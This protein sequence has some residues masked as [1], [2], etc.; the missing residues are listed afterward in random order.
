M[1]LVVILMSKVNGLQRISLAM[2]TA[3]LVHGVNGQAAPKLAL[4]TQIQPSLVFDPGPDL[5]RLL[6]SIMVSHAQPQSSKSGAQ[7][8]AA[9]LIWNLLT[10]VHGPLALHHAVVDGSRENVALLF[11]LAVVVESFPT[12]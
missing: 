1:R 3:R 2:L 7:H 11:I 8:N 12:R 5:L 4:L 9:P 6:L 10:G